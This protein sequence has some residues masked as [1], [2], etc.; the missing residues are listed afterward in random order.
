MLAYEPENIMVPI[1]NHKL[2]IMEHGKKRF[3]PNISGMTNGLFFDLIDI[4][5]RNIQKITIRFCG[6]DRTEFT[7]ELIDIFAIKITNTCFYISFSDES[8]VSDIFKF[9]TEG[10]ANLSRCDF[11]ITMEFRKNI[12]NAKLILRYIYFNQYNI[13]TNHFRFSINPYCQL[14]KCPKLQKKE[15]SPALILKHLSQTI[16]KSID[17]YLVHHIYSYIY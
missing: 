17:H 13:K 10:M 3:L 11:F 14:P 12:K 1:W 8:T 9:K 2:L 16:D 5:I 4:H 6:A 7:R 15:I